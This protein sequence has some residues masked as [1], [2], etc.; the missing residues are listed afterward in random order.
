M[1]IHKTVTGAWR[2]KWRVNGQQRSRN[3]DRRGDA[4]TFEA[5]MKR[6]RQL[7]PALAA[8]LDRSMMTLA[9]YVSGP[10]RAHAATL[11]PASRAG[12]KWALEK[13][14]TE[15][16]DEPLASI[17]VPLLAEHQ[18]ALLRRGAT[19][20]TVREAFV[21]LSGIMQIAVEHGHIP[22]N[23]VRALRKVRIEAQDEVVALSPVELERLLAALHGRDKA[24]CLLG[25]HLGLRP[26]ELRQV[27]WSVL[28][29]R[30]LVVGKSVTKVTARR[31]RTIAVPQT[32]ARELREWRLRSGRPSDTEP[33]VGEMS[34]NAL[35]L[36]GARHLRPAVKAATNGRI[37]DAT[38]YSL[39]HS[40]ASALHYCGFTVPEAARRMGHGA[41]LHLKV[42]AHVIET[43]GSDR[44]AGIDE[45]IAAARADLTFPQSSPAQFRG[46]SDAP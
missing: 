45:L 37:T 20:S 12:Y 30:T 7:G 11:S 22:G 14:L 28:G 17:D 35:K 10:W 6:R 18:Q 21:R 42:Y 5:E 8:E 19:P 3:F 16:V 40:A 31:T 34:P 38:V 13:H 4:V 44:Y 25:G 33:I 46:R 24:I 2:V 27:P 43:M 36:W 39:R 23:P 41:E 32:T 29:D 1:S 26:L 15:L 9:D